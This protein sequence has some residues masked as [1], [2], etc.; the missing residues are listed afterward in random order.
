MGDQRLKTRVIK[1]NCNPEW[2]EEL[3]LQ[4]WNPSIPIKLTVF[5]KDRFSDDDRM[6]EADIDINPYLECLA[7]GLEDLPAG[8][9]VKKIQPSR[10]NCLADESKVV[11]VKKGHMVQDMILRLKNV[12]RGEVQIQL[13]WIDIFPTPTSGNS[14]ASR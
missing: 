7:M 6:G 1:K 9:A 3:T 12:E 14:K 8:T 13:E 4:I 11:W 5:D 2:N 10:S